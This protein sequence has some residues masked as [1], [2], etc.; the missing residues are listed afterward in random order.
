MI[1]EATSRIPGS[2]APTNRSADELKMPQDENLEFRRGSIITLFA[3]DYE[4]EPE[5]DA[6][7]FDTRD[8][9]GRN[10]FAVFHLADGRLRFVVAGPT[11]DKTLTTGDQFSF[12]AGIFQEVGV[13][14]SGD[15]MEIQLNS[16]SKAVDDTVVVLPQAFNTFIYLFQTATVANRMEGELA[17]FEIRRDVQ[18]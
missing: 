11:A 14:W 17:T 9:T 5:A 7:L 4:G 2:V 6:C 18:Q 1:S 13:S 8:E 10:G 3:P 16:D 12:Q 15:F